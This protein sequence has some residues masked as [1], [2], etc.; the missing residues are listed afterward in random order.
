MTITRSVCD[1]I[2]EV[3]KILRI[4]AV[5]SRPWRNKGIQKSPDPP[6][7]LPPS[8]KFSLAGLPPWFKKFASIIIQG[9]ETTNFSTAVS[10]WHALNK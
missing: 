9:L 2:K 4:R 1:V 3:K 7:S 8:S 10:S 5:S 6:P